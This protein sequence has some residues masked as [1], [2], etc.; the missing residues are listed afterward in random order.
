MKNESDLGVALTRCFFCG[1]SDRILLSTR[2]T[3]KN[4]ENVRAA[5]DKIIDLEPRAKCAD[6]MKRRII[7]LPFDPA[8]SEPGWEKG[9]IPNP[10]RT[11]GFYVLKEEA[12]RRIFSG[13]AID[14]AVKSRWI[15]VEKE[16]VEQLG[17]PNSS[18]E[19]EEGAAS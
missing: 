15:F 16:V 9:P 17:L 18:T 11:G 14:W 3:K 5:H 2:L 8:R 12:V 4:A 1:E 13:P 10:Y 19:P 6:L 7:L